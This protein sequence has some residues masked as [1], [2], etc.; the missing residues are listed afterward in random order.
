MS[1]LIAKLLYPIYR[2]LHERHENHVK[3]DNLM[4]QLN[5]QKESE[6]IR[7]TFAFGRTWYI[8]GESVTDDSASPG[9]HPLY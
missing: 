2:E 6:V 9:L 8:K 3:Y 4:K 7:E 5:E 1:K